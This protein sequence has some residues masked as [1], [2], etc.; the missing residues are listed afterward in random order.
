M[1]KIL[2]T[3]FI[4]TLSTQLMVAQNLTKANHLFVKREYL[5]AA[6]L[7]LKETP[8]TQ[9]IYEHLGDC[10]YFNSLMKD[11]SA[12]YKILITDYES[13]LD[14]TYL[15]RYSESLKGIGK[16]KEAEKWLEKFNE[17][18]N[19]S[20]TIDSTSTVQKTLKFEI[21]E[22]PTE[23][24]YSN[25]GVGFLENSVVFASTRS[26]GTLYKWN[27]KPF[28]DLYTAELDETG[29]F[30]N[31]ELFSKNI[32][33]KMHESNAIFT[34]DGKT[35]YFTRNNYLNGKK[36][37]D[38]NKVSNLKIY[39]AEFINNE[40]TNVTDLPFNNAD[41]SVEHPALSPDEKKLYFASD[42]PG[43][44]GSFDIFVVDILEDGSY[45]TPKNLGE[46]INT[47]QRE[48]FPFI[49]NNN[50]LYFASNGYNGFG[51]LDIYKSTISNDVYSKPLNLGN[52]I[53]SNLDDFAFV[54]T[55]KDDKG[56]FASNRNSSARN[57]N[58]Y[59]FTQDTMYFVQGLVQHKTTLKPLPGSVVSLYNENDQLISEVTTDSIASFSIEIEHDKSYK[60]SASEYLYHP[61]D[62]V[63]KTA[64]SGN[65]NTTI[66]LL[67]ETKEEI[68]V[69]NNKTQLRIAPVYFDFDKWNIR[70]DA[71]IELD[72]VIAIMRKYPDMNIEVG[73]HTD[74]R[75]TAA[76]NM[77]LS[78]KRAKS[79]TQYLEK[80]GISATRLTWVGYGESEPLNDCANEGGCTEKE[81]ALNRR[82]E[83]VTSKGIYDKSLEPKTSNEDEDNSKNENE[84]SSPETYKVVKNDTMY[85]IS[86]KFGLT[87]NEIMRLNNLNSS[88]IFVGQ[89][90]IV[91]NNNKLEIYTVK[92]GD[93]LS[94]ISKKYE[95]SLNELKELNYLESNKITVGQ[96]LIVKVN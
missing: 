79:V 44:I 54:L 62:T 70:P 16:N 14:P 80:Q 13:T 88:D 46:N 36:G 63:F 8:K 53:N 95:I 82:S 87:V 2:I 31:I 52:T 34:K 57:D 61:T 74:S 67:L 19:N 60:L 66:L 47:A 3:L 27:N 30:E 4:C 9:E 51:G 45:G 25:F 96:K 84:T 91:K 42:M 22:I 77:I 28:L 76:Y 64:E 73:G 23:P 20:Q 18:M 69:Q 29:S 93:N 5:N 92:K 7:Y 12:Y 15:F 65:I 21:E 41:Y 38:A 24:E 59:K 58:I 40:W 56:Y 33:T 83:F 1:K 94:L 32:N 17:L 26:D 81:Y 89:K 11:A 49:S 72:N 78:D 50:E 55:K 43:T 35:M 90:L 68:M 37:K 85:L 48:Q 6:E 75:G 86:L 71:A 39:K 10:Y